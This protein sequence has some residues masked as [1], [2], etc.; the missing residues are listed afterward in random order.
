M[1]PLSIG[2]AFTFISLCNYYF[3]NVE[4]RSHRSGSEIAFS[5]NARYN[6]SAS[7]HIDR[8]YKTGR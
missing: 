5:G 2:Y 4:A 3:E 1:N 6:Y 8:T 7:D